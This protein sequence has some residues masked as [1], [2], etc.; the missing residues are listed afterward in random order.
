MD[1]K[2]YKYIK[3]ETGNFF[4]INDNNGRQMSNAEIRVKSIR[5]AISLAEMGFGSGDVFGIISKNHHHLAPIVFA[6][7]CLAAPFNTLD[8]NFK[9]GIENYENYE[10]PILNIVI[11]SGDFANACVDPTESDILRRL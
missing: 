1:Q 8:P 10:K 9:K 2:T 6:A 3:Y 5:A 4:Q 7:A 11:F